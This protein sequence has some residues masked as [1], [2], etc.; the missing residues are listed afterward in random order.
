MK[1][2]Q[3]LLLT[4]LFFSSLLPAQSLYKIFKF[5]NNVQPIPYEMPQI[6]V[7][8]SEG[9][10]GYVYLTGTLRIALYNQ[11]QDQMYLAKMTQSG[12]VKW[13]KKYTV[14]YPMQVPTPNSIKVFSDGPLYITGSV[15]NSGNQHSDAFLMKLDTAGSVIRT[16]FYSS[17][18]PNNST[19]GNDQGLNIYQFPDLKAGEKI[20]SGLFGGGEATLIKI[21]NLNGVM[22][23]ERTGLTN[24]PNRFWNF[25]TYAVPGYGGYINIGQA[26][27]SSLKLFYSKVDTTFNLNALHVYSLNGP[28][29]PIGPS[30]IQSIQLPFSNDFIVLGTASDSIGDMYILARLDVNGNVLWVKGYHGFEWVAK[31]K[32][33][34]HPDGKLIIV[35]DEPYNSGP[36]RGKIL[37]TDLDGNVLQAV[38]VNHVNYAYFYNYTLYFSTAMISSVDSSLMIFG[39]GY[40][41][42]NTS[43]YDYGH[44]SMLKFKNGADYVASQYCFMDIR[45]VSITIDSSLSLSNGI[46]GF[47]SNKDFAH[48]IELSFTDTG[49]LYVD[50]VEGALA[51]NNFQ[52]N[53]TQFAVG[54]TISASFSADNYISAYVVVQDCGTWHNVDPLMGYTFTCTGTDTVKLMVFNSAY[55]YNATCID[56]AILVVEVGNIGLN[57]QQSDAIVISPNPA[58][59][60]FRISGLEPGSSIQVFDINGQELFARKETNQS[61]LILDTKNWN[62][63]MYF[64]Q[65]ESNIFGKR[66]W[67]LVVSH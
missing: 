27:H 26:D 31:P 2:H 37:E 58:D 48:T 57:K 50:T 10:D 44:L 39:T 43:M 60:H 3:L 64:V 17:W 21:G 24:W 4:M 56:S 35:D 19:Y 6:A 22:R 59:E 53:K 25:N 46:P 49:M 5:Y 18:D 62:A 16:D 15:Y 45:P 14:E 63:G 11:Y 32:L 55:Q 7:Q 23:G 61:G 52:V 34:Y 28:S 30:N 47:Y 29:S 42:Y 9:L 41:G 33:L 1:K 36:R 12:D 51:I 20:I 65:I 38:T 67:K 13:V 40:D 66:R 8:A 54:E